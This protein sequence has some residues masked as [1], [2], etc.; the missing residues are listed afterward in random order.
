MSSEFCLEELSLSGIVLGYAASTV[1]AS[2]EQEECLFPICPD[3]LILGT[4]EFYE[5]LSFCDDGIY[6]ISDGL[7]IGWLASFCGTGYIARIDG[8]DELGI[9][10]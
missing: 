5:L 8:L 7:I 2:L 1:P 6:T 4:S 10:R 9:L 3:I